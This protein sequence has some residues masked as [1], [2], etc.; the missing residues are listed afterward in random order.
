MKL[1]YRKHAIVRMFERGISDDD[2]TDAGGR[3]THGAVAEDIREIL[4]TGDIIASYPDDRPYPSQL[5][6]GWIDNKPMHV[7]TAETDNGEIIIITA[8]H[9]EPTLWEDNFTRRR[10]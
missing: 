3:A 1:I 7:L 10:S 8:Y 4:T 2:C 5:L 6:L 9:P